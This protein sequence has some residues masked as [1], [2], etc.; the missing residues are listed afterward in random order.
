[1]G[2]PSIRITNPIANINP[3][4]YAGIEQFASV[5]GAWVSNGLP[6][7]NYLTFKWVIT[8]P[9]GGGG[10]T[11]SN[12][13]TQL[14]QQKGYAG[15][16]TNWDNADTGPMSIANTAVPGVYTLTLTITSGDGDGRF[17]YGSTQ[18]LVIYP[19]Y[20]TTEF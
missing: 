10:V 11:F 4:K 17:V 7:R 8:P 6:A 15:G 5:N 9:T 3:G 20:M 18:L 2:E 16:P 19:G 1:V 12:G 13:T 14:T